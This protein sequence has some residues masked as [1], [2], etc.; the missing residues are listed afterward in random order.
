MRDLSTLAVTKFLE[1]RGV[2][3]T[4]IV[5]WLGGGEFAD[6][7]LPV[8]IRPIARPETTERRHSLPLEG[9]SRLFGRYKLCC[10][11]QKAV[12]RNLFPRT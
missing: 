2:P 9:D 12:W 10:R 8:G 1:G 3:G 7:V 11:C 6:A 4:G 5:G